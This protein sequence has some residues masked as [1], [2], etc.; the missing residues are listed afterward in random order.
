M[1]K[2]IETNNWKELI[3]L[4]DHFTKSHVNIE[5]LFRGQAINTWPLKSSITR[6]LPTNISRKEA[7]KYEYDSILNFTFEYNSF[8]ED[9]IKIETFDDISKL[10]IMQHHKSPTRLLD[11]SNSFY[12]SLYFAV[13]REFESNG[14][15]YI[16]PAHILDR[17]VCIKYPELKTGSIDKYYND[18]ENEIIIRIVSKFKTKRMAMQQGWSTICNNIF[19]DHGEVIS[20]YIDV[21]NCLFKLIINGQLKIE[22][23]DRLR[24]MNISGK[25]IYPCLDGL[26]KWNEENIHIKN[27]LKKLTVPD[28]A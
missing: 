17:N 1:W 5:W 23:L 14:A 7:L 16:F 28:S 21:D 8:K 19:A 25:T 10:L 26:G 20:N 22:I 18:E 27:Y 4:S 3:E 9:D 13:E 15:I 11:W 6:L 12:L 2:I 24:H